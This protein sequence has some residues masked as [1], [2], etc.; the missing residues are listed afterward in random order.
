MTTTLKRTGDRAGVS[1]WEG[2]R[3]ERRLGMWLARATAGIG[4]AYVVTFIIG[5][6]SMG[7]LSKPLEDPYLAIAEFLILVMA[8]I[9]VLLMVIVHQC[10][11]ERTRIYSMSAVGWMLLLA[12]FT[13]TVHVVELTA[14]RRLSATAIPGSAYLFGWHWPSVFYAIDVVAWD[15]FFGLAL[16]F[17]VPVFHATGHTAARNGLLVAGCL[18]I[19]GMIGPAIGHIAW[20]E[21]GILGYAIVFPIACVA[22]SRAFRDSPVSVSDSECK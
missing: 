14:V 1:P 15:V 9:L 19:L 3:A 7:D 16:L 10:A 20:R 4:A 6:A 17:A 18:S 11:P 2:A 13:M 21:I 22:I 8:P 12:G 5:F